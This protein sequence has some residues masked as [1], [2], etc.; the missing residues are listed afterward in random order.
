M[1]GFEA[2][3]AQFEVLYEI[4]SDPVWYLELDEFQIMTVFSDFHTLAGSGCPFMDIEIEETA[5]DSNDVSESRMALARE[6]YRLA[7]AT[8]VENHYFYTWCLFKTLAK[9]SVNFIYTYIT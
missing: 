6:M 4:H 9:V 8:D 7:V 3:T 2:V 1:E 5:F